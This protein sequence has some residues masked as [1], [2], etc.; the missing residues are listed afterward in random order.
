MLFA[1]IKNHSNF[2]KGALN[3]YDL[4]QSIQADRAFFD[5]KFDIET[6]SVHSNL[7]KDLEMN[8]RAEQIDFK[9]D[10]YLFLCNKVVLERLQFESTESFYYRY[11]D[12]NK[13]EYKNHTTENE[14]YLRKIRKS[15][16]KK[17]FRKT[18]TNASFNQLNEY[19]Q[20]SK[21]TLSVN[22]NNQIL[23]SSP[24]L[25][26][27][28]VKHSNVSNFINSPKNRVN[29]LKQKRAKRGQ[30]RKYESE[31]LER[32]VEVVLSGLM[33]VHKAGL[34]FGVP[35]STLEYKVKERTIINENYLS[36]K[37]SYSAPNYINEGLNSSFGQIW[38]HN[39]SR[40]F[41]TNFDK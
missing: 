1:K 41:G 3:L 2:F 36:N 8:K 40:N 11:L 24:T 34:C 33:S 27:S 30:Y 28:S 6:K 15:Y 39:Q 10:L 17:L 35:H 25:H 31:Q 38:P 21:T 4:P 26:S 20:Q 18:F 19:F 9:D 37:L 13:R 7:N 29:Y 32:A 12:E 16:F 23:T 5:K 14:K 22:S